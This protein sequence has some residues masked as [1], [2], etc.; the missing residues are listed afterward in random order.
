[1]GQSM[2]SDER[3][4]TPAGAFAGLVEELATSDDV[5]LTEEF[6]S[7]ELERRRIG[8]RMAAIVREAE[9]RS[10]PVAD[11]HRS[12]K[13]WIRAHTNCGGGEANRLR[14]LADATDTVPGVGEALLGGHI[15]GGQADEL[16]R[17]RA[18]PRCGDQLP[19]SAEMLLEHA[20][21]L[22]Y[23]EFRTVVKRWET[24]ADLDGAQLDDD[25]SHERRT[26]SVR[27]TPDVAGRGLDV[28]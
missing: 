5:S 22:S 20:E 1:M 19:A 9:R 16:A 23:E 27:T 26:A 2:A 6:R 11:G 18:N 17:A 14:K 21:H 25:A 24:L 4:V 15:G 28:T 7:L 12:T 3:D 13:S 10:L 8:A